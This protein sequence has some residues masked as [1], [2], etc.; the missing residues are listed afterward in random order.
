VKVVIPWV[1]AL[2]VVIGAGVG[3]EAGLGV[4]TP[5]LGTVDGKILQVEGAVLGPPFPVYGTITL[6]N[7]SSRVSYHASC[8]RTSGFSVTVPPGTYSLSGFSG[9]SYSDGEAVS[10][11]PFLVRPGA[12]VQI[13]L[14]VG[15]E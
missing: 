4:G 10:A 5:A 7:V 8:T 12:T 11:G 6:T 2:L 9:H 14:Y 13:T 3:V 1:L 15:S